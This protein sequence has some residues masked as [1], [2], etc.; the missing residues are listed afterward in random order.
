MTQKLINHFKNSKYNNSDLF[1]IS[2]LALNTPSKRNIKSLKEIVSE[3]IKTE[4]EI[5]KSSDDY[6][7]EKDDLAYD[8]DLVLIVKYL[9]KELKTNLSK[10]LSN[11][12][13]L[14]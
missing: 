1:T 5:C 11:F 10:E 9:E 13:Y 6:F 8:I 4:E 12:N 7:G 2:L 14:N 3:C